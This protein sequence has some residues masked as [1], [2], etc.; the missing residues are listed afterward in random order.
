MEDTY[1]EIFTENESEDLVD[2]KKLTGKRFY[3]AKTYNIIGAS[4]QARGEFKSA[5]KNF[6]LAIEIRPDYA[7]AHNNIGI[8]HHNKGNL[9]LALKS[10]KTA[11]KLEPDHPEFNHNMATL[12]YDTSDY[13]TAIKF[14]K[15]N[16]SSDSQTDLLKCF[17]K[18]GKPDSFY[19][20][21]DFLL[22]RGDNNA[23][24]GRYISR[25]ETKYGIK[26][27]NPFCQNPLE[28]VLQTNIL[29]LCDFKNI[30]IKGSDEILNNKLISHNNI[31]IV[32]N[33]IK[34]AGNLFSLETKETR[35]IKNIIHLEIEKYWSL[36]KN[37]NE[38]LIRE[39]PKKY[40]VSGWILSLM[41]GGSVQPHMHKQGWVS[42]SI[43]IN[44]PPKVKADSGNLVVCLD[45]ATNKLSNNQNLKSLDVRTGSL[46]LFPSSLPHYTVPFEGQKNRIVLGFDIIPK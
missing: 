36:F 16:N 45:D 35:Q 5:M 33:G 15:K 17:Y 46:C 32:K 13:K 40:R 4:Q 42:G 29:D 25:A 30:F 37:S 1:K 7:E 24:M 27:P 12:L 21:V 28:Y 3:E 2:Q 10:F 31:E 38:G 8:L 11:I 44:V 14:F 43:Y 34:T 20:Q 6:K 18:L 19:N 9:I 22:K 26:R 41:N 39:R 23:T